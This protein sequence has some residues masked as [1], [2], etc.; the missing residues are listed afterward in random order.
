MAVVERRKLLITYPKREVRELIKNMKGEYFFFFVATLILS[1][2]SPVLGAAVFGLFLAYHYLNFES[3]F[4]SDTWGHYKFEMLPM[5]PSQYF[6]IGYEVYD[7]P[8][9]LNEHLAILKEG[10]VKK[11]A[12]EWQKVKKFEKYRIVGLSKDVLTRH[13]WIL[14][15]TGAGK[16]SLIMSAFKEL[17]ACGAGVIFVDGKADMD[18]QQ[19]CYGL[20]RKAGRHPSYY[21]INFLK[22]E[23]A[24]D[25]TN[26]FSPLADLPPAGQIDFLMNLMSVSGGGGD[27]AY[28][29]GRGK[30]LLSPVVYGLFFRRQYWGE[31]YTYRN[32]QNAL[33]TREYAF[34]QIFLTAI[35]I[36]VNQRLKKN[37]EI[38]PILTQAQE[39]AT[40]ATPLKELELI[41]NYLTQ[42][43]DR[44]SI[45]KAGEDPDF[46]QDL[47]R[48]YTLG[49]ATYAKTLSPKWGENLEA[50]AQKFREYV[51]S[52]EKNI[53]EIDSAAARRAFNALL[54]E[55]AQLFELATTLEEK[56][57]TQHNYAQQQWTR[58]FGAFESY[59]HI[60]GA[61]DPEVSIPRTLK[62][63]H[64]IYVLLPVLEKDDDTVSLLGKSILVNLFSA[65]A[66]A[67]GYKIDNLSP[68]QQKIITSRVKPVPMGLIVLDE[69]G[70][71]P[72]PR[73]EVLFAQ[74]RS[75]RVSIWIATQDLVSAKPG[76][77]E[78]A[79]ER[80]FGSSNKIIMKLEDTRAKDMI[81]KNITPKRILTENSVV[82]AGNDFL[83]EMTATEKTQDPYELLKEASKFEKG[84]SIFSIDGRQVFTQVKWEDAPPVS[85]ILNRYKRPS[86]FA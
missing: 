7:D 41:D 66:I 61:I 83:P 62:E 16:T 28:W 39:L 49:V 68:T 34:Y 15:A 70:A 12:Q 27:H 21:V 79:L 30:A 31:N 17:F 82:A 23:M 37:Q 78:D 81:S 4:P 80:I 63:N 60:F 5:T 55:E 20:A 57:Q 22:P 54:K 50:A 32:L 53:L 85:S 25:E 3:R 86:Y 26:T 1:F 10:D 44:E 77:K 48:V 14:G 72:I 45:R 71:Y 9:S 75:I 8:R 35:A 74:C 73:V 40:P 43:R 19:K 24:K 36:E 64:I 42:T 33:S 47:F 56:D 59:S 84:F 69:Y 29:E 51:N 46:L 18:M 13:L 65:T 2:L 67:L 76:G 52:R 6:Q 38:A 58:V 11:L